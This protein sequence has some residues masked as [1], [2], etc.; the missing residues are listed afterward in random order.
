MCF[1]KMQGYF[2]IF[3]RGS[4][5]LEITK[6]DPEG[7]GGLA[8]NLQFK[9]PDGKIVDLTAVDCKFKFGKDHQNQNF[10]IVDTAADALPINPAN[11]F[12]NCD[13]T[14]K[15]TWVSVSNRGLITYQIDATIT[16]D[17]VMNVQRYGPGTSDIILFGSNSVGSFSL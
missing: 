4:D 12:L 2:K 17:T 1:L 5:L 8:K 16:V 10:T 6:K 15:S 13:Q 14:T 3:W 11:I 9:D 7:V